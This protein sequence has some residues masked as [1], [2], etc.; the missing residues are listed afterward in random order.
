MTCI[1]KYA[2]FKAGLTNAV[3]PN[4]SSWHTAEEVHFTTSGSGSTI[5][6]DCFPTKKTDFY[7]YGSYGD[8][9]YDAKIHCDLSKQSIAAVAMTK[10]WNGT[11]SI[12]Y[13]GSSWA[14]SVTVDYY[15]VDWIKKQM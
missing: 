15:T 7:S 9:A 13:G 5:L 4:P 8:W 1:E 6:N 11:A 2:F 3:L 10:S 12:T 14:P